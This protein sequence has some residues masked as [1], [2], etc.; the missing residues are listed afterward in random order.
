[1]K[2]TSIASQSCDS[3][4]RLHSNASAVA[5]IL[6]AIAFGQSHHGRIQQDS[7]RTAGQCS[8][9][10]KRL[11]RISRRRRLS[12]GFTRRRGH[13]TWAPSCMHSRNILIF[14]V[15]IRGLIFFSAKSVLSACLLDFF[16]ARVQTDQRHTIKPVPELFK[17]ECP[18]IIPMEI[19]EL[20]SSH[21]EYCHVA[22]F[23]KSNY[24]TS[25]ASA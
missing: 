10:S 14:S 20:S 13:V 25:S 23:P 2:V 18:G 8:K 16:A 5:I 17:C 11:T 3:V 6:R 15:Q 22:A 12:H 19:C 1:M 9:A 7:P 24:P 4:K 21:A